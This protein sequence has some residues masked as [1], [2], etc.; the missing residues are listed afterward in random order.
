VQQALYAQLGAVVETR[1]S[2]GDAGALDNS[3][4]GAVQHMPPTTPGRWDVSGGQPP[5]ADHA[6]QDAKQLWADAYAA[7]RWCA[8]E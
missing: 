7:D 5:A 6:K 1:G 4:R 8:D 2:G 3:K